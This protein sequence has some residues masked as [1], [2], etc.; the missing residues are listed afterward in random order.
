MKRMLMTVVAITL[1][2][3]VCGQRSVDDLFKKYSGNDGYVTITVNGDL[4]RLAEL[5]DDDR[6]SEGHKNWPAEITQIR[7]LAQE[8]ENRVGENFYH[9]VISEI[10]RDNYEEF[11]KVK[12]KDQDLVMLVRSEGRNFK[13]FLMVAGG[14][15]NLIIQIK[16]NLK[17]KDAKRISDD[18]RHN[19]DMDLIS[20]E[21]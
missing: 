5:F 7:I 13:E 2:L 18:F 14:E 15:D 10:S 20:C 3:L 11:M 9:M 8:N 19:H 16:G 4:L 12:E 21:N 1:T 17:M 6:D